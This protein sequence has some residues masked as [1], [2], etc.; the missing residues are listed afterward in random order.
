MKRI[1]SIDLKH[2]KAFQDT[3]PIELEGKN[4]LLY[5]P[6]GSGKSSIFWAL[7]TFL[8]S[9]QKSPADVQKY[10]DPSH[11]ESLVNIDM[12]ESAS[13][14]IVLHMGEGT[15]GES[16]VPVRIALDTHE[17]QFPIGRRRTLRVILSPTG[18]SFVSTTSQTARKLISGRSSPAKS[19]RSVPLHWPVISPMRGL[20]S[21]VMTRITRR[22]A[23]RPAEELR[24]EFTT[25]TS[26][27]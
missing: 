6:N 24:R 4:L 13:S 20:M 2:F 26:V 1:H 11:R 27:V 8:Q 19:C 17:P 16:A 12:A 5:G 25:S 7:Y 23:K 9:S 14:S 21:A 3:P 15:D 10:F 22:N 18:Y